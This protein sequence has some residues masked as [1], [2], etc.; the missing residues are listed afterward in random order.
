MARKST[1]VATGGSAVATPSA[2][3]SSCEA[4]AVTCTSGNSTG[5]GG[6]QATPR[7]SGAGGA[8]A[9]LP[10]ATVTGLDDTGVHSSNENCDAV[11]TDTLICWG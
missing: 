3:G 10:N 1:P 4:N 11:S 6:G 5:G 7:G 8:G 9:R 2:G